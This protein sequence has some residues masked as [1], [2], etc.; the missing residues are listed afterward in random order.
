MSRILTFCCALLLLLWFVLQGTSWFGEHDDKD[1]SERWRFEKD[2]WHRFHS[3]SFAR[4]SSFAALPRHVRTSIESLLYSPPHSPP[5]EFHHTIDG[6]YQGNW[7]AAALQPIANRTL[8]A[9]YERPSNGSAGRLEM[10]LTST[11]SAEAWVRLVSGYVQLQSAD[12]SIVLGLQGLYWRSNGTAVLYGVPEITAQ[13]TVDV[14]RAMPSK[15]A[16]DHA[17]KVYD[18]ALGGHLLSYTLPEDA[19]QGCSYQMYMRFDPSRESSPIELQTRLAMVS[20]QCNV[21]LSTDQKATGVTASG[22]RLKSSHYFRTVLALLLVQTILLVH[23]MRSTPTHAAMSMVSYPTLIMQIVLDSYVFV[24]HLIGCMTYGGIYLAFAVVGM[25]VYMV[26]MAFQMKYLIAVWHVQCPESADA[27][28]SS[29][30]R[31]LLGIYLRFYAV[32]IPGVYIIYAFIDH[33]SRLSQWLMGILLAAVY[34]YWIP[35]IWHNARRGIAR[36]LRPD[37]VIGTSAVRLAFPAYFFACPKNIAFIQPTWL[38]WILI[39]YSLGQAAVLVLQ[40]VLG[41]RFFIPQSMRPDDYD[42]CA[43]LPPADEE[44]RIGLDQSAVRHSRECPICMTPV[45]SLQPAEPASEHAVTPCNHIFHKQC[46][47]QWMEIKL[48]CP[49]CRASLPPV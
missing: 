34:S 38:I 43:A 14:V 28:S 33:R 40:R 10:S 27:L 23:Q 25:L 22:Y 13:T 20:P 44:S 31:G 12:V 17:K 7:H 37:Y 35:Q 49:I 6:M 18:E 26:S 42:Y 47:V 3:I 2:W 45:H 41:A 24:V 15:Q 9:D 48:E 30:R 39:A 4:N 21:R 32:L 46:L 29:G 8:P 36:R 19:Y 16:F 1:N 11:E 5:D